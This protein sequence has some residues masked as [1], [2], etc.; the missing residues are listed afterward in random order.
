M[1]MPYNYTVIYVINNI[2]TDEKRRGN[3]KKELT[4]MYKGNRLEVLAVLTD[5]DIADIHKIKSD[6]AKAR[7]EKYVQHK[8]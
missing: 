5:A 8:L 3:S 2:V 7:Y 6:K 4:E 1:P